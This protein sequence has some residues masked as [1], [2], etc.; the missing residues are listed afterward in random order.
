MDNNSACNFH[1]QTWYTL[2][3]CLPFTLPTVNFFKTKSAWNSHRGSVVNE[4]DQYLRGCRFNPQLCSMGQGSGIVMS[5]GVGCKHGSDPALLW[6]W[7]RPAAS[8]PRVPLAW[9]P[10]CAVSA[11]LKK[12]AKKKKSSVSTKYSHKNF[13]LITSK[14]LT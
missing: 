1:R 7:H 2:A 3:S 9:E 8:A 13:H 10:P 4:P 12:K 5:C 6:L 14:S 11:A